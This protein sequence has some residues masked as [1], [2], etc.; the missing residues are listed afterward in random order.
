MYDDL[1]PHAEESFFMNKFTEPLVQL[2]AFKTMLCIAHG[3]N[4]F[5][6]KKIINNGKQTSL[7]LDNFINEK[8]LL[9]FY[10]NLDYKKKA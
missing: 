1:A 6:K 5:D 8:D 7:K 4:T 2:D 9:A 3:N 10:K